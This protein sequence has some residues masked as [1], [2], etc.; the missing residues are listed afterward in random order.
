MINNFNNFIKENIENKY[1]Y[2]IDYT[3]LADNCNE[4]KIKK[5]SDSQ[6]FLSDYI[7]NL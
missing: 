1:N 6:D 3:Y 2:L 4:E 5:I 7:D